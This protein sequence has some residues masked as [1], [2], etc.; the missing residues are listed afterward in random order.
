M[1]VSEAE[2]EMRDAMQLRRFCAADDPAPSLLA[3]RKP[4]FSQP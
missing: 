1:T 4:L 2:N 3:S